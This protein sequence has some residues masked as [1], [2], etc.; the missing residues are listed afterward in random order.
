L[1]LFQKINLLFP[2]KSGNIELNREFPIPLVKMAPVLMLKAVH[3][4]IYALMSNVISSFVKV[5][6][7][8]KAFVLILSFIYVSN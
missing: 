5:V 2:K 7:Y 8:V 3:I 1:Q 6:T 4:L